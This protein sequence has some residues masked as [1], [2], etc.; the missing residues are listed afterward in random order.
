MLLQKIILAG[1][2]LGT[3]L[4]AIAE[5]VLAPNG[6]FDTPDG[7]LWGIAGEA[8]TIFDFPDTGG[9]PGGFASIDNPGAGFGVLI[10]N[11]EIDPDIPLESLGL[12]AGESYEFFQDMIILSGDELGR[13]RV[14]FFIDGAPS[15]DSGILTAPLIG[16]GS[17]WETYTF[18]VT[19]P[20]NINQIRIVPLWGVGSE[21]GYDNIGVNN[22][23]VDGPEFEPIPNPGFEPRDPIGWTPSDNNF[24]TFPETGGNPG[25]FAQIDASGGDFAQITSNNNT[26]ILLSTLGITPGET[27]TFQVDMRII[28][29]SNIGRFTVEFIPT[30]TGILTPALIGDGSTWE[31]YSFDI[32]I[33]STSTQIFIILVSGD[34]SVVGYDNVRVDLP[35]EEPFSADIETGTILS[36]TPTSPDNSYQ[37][38]SSD[39]GEDFFNFGP[40]IMG[41]SPSS[42]FDTE[43]AAFFR[44]IENSL[45]PFDNISNGGFESGEDGVCPDDWVCVGMEPTRTTAAAQTGDASAQILIQNVGAVGNISEIQQNTSV[46]PGDSLDFSFS[47]MRVSANGTFASTYQ[48]Q[49]L[50]DNGFIGDAV[51]A[52]PIDGPLGEWVDFSVSGLVPP[53]DASNALIQIRAVT[54]AIDGDSGEVLI[55]DVVFTALEVDTSEVIESTTS[56]AVN[57]FFQSEEGLSYQVQ[58]ATDLG[59][60]EDFGEAF[61]GTGGILSISEAID[62]PTNF[63]QVIE[64]P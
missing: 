41:E 13:F 36:W 26:P 30:G 11:A 42:I 53:D 63:Y 64:S 48:I 51:P 38:Q 56:P 17:T 23:P 34:D 15:G 6:N 61:T 22:T 62:L 60:F 9:N 46:F 20:P 18:L 35:I 21:V 37:P 25:G 40:A 7:A 50:G 10:A 54:G 49:W 28:S 47:A 4:S 58:S 44:V 24:V 57:I 39:N 14:E 19:L 31:T 29:G 45:F 43:G 52:T 59:T 32:T 1:A 16:D 2:I 12:V 55:D 3:A 8:D 5:P 33:P 27:V